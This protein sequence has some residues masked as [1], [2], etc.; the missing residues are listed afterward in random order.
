[1][2]YE[3]KIRVIANSYYNMGLEKAK[4]RDLSGSADCL[5]KCLHFNKYMTDARNLLGLIYY[6]VGEVGDALV[7]WVISKNL[8]PEDNRADYYLEA[9]QKKKGTMDLERKAVR[10]FNQ[11][12]AY[13][14]SGSEDL[15]I[16]Q[17]NKAVEDKPNYIKAQ[18]LFALL[19]LVRE[20]HQ[21]A[22]KAVNKVLQIDRNNSKA[23]YY[24][25]IM[26]D[27]GTKIKPERE[28]EKRKLKNVLSHRQM[29]DDDVIIPPSYKENTRD[30]AVLN[31]MAGLLLGAAVVFFL[32]MPANTK[33]INENHNK[34]ILKYSEQL[35]Q[36][37][38]KADLLSQQ[39]KSLESEKKTAE[40]SLASLTNNSDSILAQYQA[41]I[42]ILQAY[43]KNDFP[44]SVK[45]YAGLNPELIASADVQAI[46]AEIKKDMTQK[47]CP[48]LEDLG[49]KAM[50]SGDNQS[51]L[52][53]Y[54]KCIELKP[55]S[56]QAKFNTAVIYKG[57]DQ[58]DQANA[59]FSDIINNSKDETLSAKAKSERGF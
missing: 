12:L 14:K 11:A 59:L 56:W 30:Q 9:I 25:S 16:L 33:S 26:K 39:L 32:V 1:M 19:C 52:N 40:E 49:D 5:K 57:M 35:S 53:Y 41:V 27:T 29:Q 50:K 22:G 55:D 34:E 6:E 28:P 43:K 45:I 13:I 2:D 36:A 46:I 18:L 58:K 47:G 7:Q 51:A 54:G 3:R 20:E 37:N 48:I 15:A 24:K 4:L 8:Q 31:I 38:Q 10:R 17:L 44:S 42:G 21:K 23:L